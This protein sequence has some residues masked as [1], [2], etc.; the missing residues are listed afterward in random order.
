MPQL[1]EEPLRGRLAVSRSYR[2]PEVPYEYR[3]RRYP[4]AERLLEQAEA[5]HGRPP[6]S[7]TGLAGAPVSGAQAAI[8][9]KGPRCTYCGRPAAWCERDPC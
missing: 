1:R 9:R 6:V 5:E 8:E 2:E 4:W 3:G 7:P